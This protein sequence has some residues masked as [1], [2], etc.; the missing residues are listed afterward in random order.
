MLHT[1]YLSFLMIPLI[2]Y[3]RY[4][5]SDS[6]ILL[7]YEKITDKMDTVIRL[8]RDSK[9]AKMSKEALDSIDDS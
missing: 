2:A 5:L 8:T 7:H 3:Y 1:G 6:L 4:R 9:M